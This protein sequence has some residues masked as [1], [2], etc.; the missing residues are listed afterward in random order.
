ML[1]CSNLRSSRLNL[2][3]QENTRSIVLNR[4]LNIAWSNSLFRPRFLFFLLRLFS[5]MLGTMPALKIIFLFFL[6]SY[7]P[8]RLITE[9]K[10]SIPTAFA[11]ALSLLNASGNNLVSFVLPGDV[12]NGATTLQFLSHS[13]T[14]LSPVRCLWPLLP[15]LSPLFLPQS[16]CHLREER[17][18]LIETPSQALQPTPQILGQKNHCWSSAES[19]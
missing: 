3:S 10:I 9:P 19:V 1:W 17:W 13:A 5:L 11:I 6:E 18:C 12:T 16:L 15:I 14:I 8:S 4:S 7:A 2:S